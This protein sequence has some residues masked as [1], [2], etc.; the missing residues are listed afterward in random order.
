MENSLEK[1]IGGELLYKAIKR[2]E[3]KLYKNYLKRIIQI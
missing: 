3:K 1:I 2:L